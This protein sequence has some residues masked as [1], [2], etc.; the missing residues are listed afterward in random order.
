[1]DRSRLVVLQAGSRILNEER[2]DRESV[3]IV[4][5]YAEENIPDRADLPLD[6]LATVVALRLMDVETDGLPA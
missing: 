2:P 6:Q 3:D 5:G 4:I 1:M